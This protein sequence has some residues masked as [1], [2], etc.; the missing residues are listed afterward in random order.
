LSSMSKALLSEIDAFLADKPFG[1]YAF[2]LKA[3]NN[4]RLVQRLREDG[5][6]WPEQEERIRAFM[7]DY[8]PSKRRPRKA[9]AA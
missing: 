3:V 9:E 5:R 7:R 1:D 4:G 6:V 2:G 8:R